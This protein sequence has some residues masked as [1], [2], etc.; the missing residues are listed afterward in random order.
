MGFGDWLSGLLGTQNNF[1]ATAPV[2][3]YQANGA[4]YAQAAQG[5]LGTAAGNEQQQSGY[6]QQLQQQASGGGAPSP[7]QMLLQQATTRNNQQAAG[8]V[9]SQRGMNPGLAAKLALDQSAQQNQTAAGQGAVLRSQEQLNAQGLLGQALGQQGAQANQLAGIGGGLDLQSQ[10]INAGVAAQNANLNLGAQQ[11]NAGVASQNA[12]T[13]G[14]I[15]GGLLGGAGE[16]AGGFGGGGAGLQAGGG[17]MSGGGMPGGTG[18]YG[19]YIA[20]HGG[21]VPGQAVVPGD[22]PRNDKVPIEASPDEVVLPR[23][24]TMAEDAPERAKHFMMAMQKRVLKKEGSGSRM[25]D[26]GVV[27]KADPQWWEDSPSPLPDPTA[28]PAQDPSGFIQGDRAGAA[29]YLAPGPPPGPLA[30]PPSGPVSL[31]QQP[32]VGPPA[33]AQAAPAPAPTQGSLPGASQQDAG[34]LATGKAKAEGLGKIA[35]IASKA[36][37]T[38]AAQAQQD[39]QTVQQRIAEQDSRAKQIADVNPNA[40]WQNLGTAG[41]ISSSIGLIL[42]GIGAGLTKGPNYAFESIQ[43]AIQNDIEAQKFNIGKKENELSRYMQGTHDLQAAQH[44]L[45]AQH[46]AVAA[47]QIESAAAKLGSATALPEAQAMIGLAKQKQFE[48]TQAA[49]LRGQQI[50][51]NSMQMDFAQRRMQIMQ[52]A[53]KSNDPNAMAIAGKR[54]E[55]I[56]HPE[57]MGEETVTIPDVRTAPDAK[58]VMHTGS[59]PVAYYGKSKEH[60]NEAQKSVSRLNTLETSFGDIES[61]FQKNPMGGIPASEDVGKV[62]AA[63]KMLA[64]NLEGAISD[65]NRPASPETLKA[66][67]EIVGSPEAFFKSPAKYEGQMK[68]IRQVLNEKRQS[69]IDGYTLGRMD[70]K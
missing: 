41:K 6:I 19:T 30:G 36:A 42:G 32:F 43:K 12:G 7:A 27:E 31:G 13:A 18:N 20:A 48:E 10:G 58:G 45:A 56:D 4:P 70:G 35:D 47:A 22:S 63:A 69:I 29:G 49:T 53:V 57:K 60:A 54:L 51:Q 61:F 46:W 23:S 2:N 65:V 33:P 28:P 64:T 17:G 15:V 16:A 52:D 21:R 37:E 67:D 34:M 38:G 1:Q 68:F 55:Y 25:A 5:A 62:R 11:I 39:A 26:G 50:K 14:S 8:A 66:M 9:A 24:V 59:V 44:Q 3:A 40:Y